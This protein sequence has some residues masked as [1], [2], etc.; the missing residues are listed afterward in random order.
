MGRIPDG[1]GNLV[2]LEVLFA[3][4]NQLSGPIPFDIGRLQKLNKFF[5]DINFLSGTIP[6]SFG[7]LS[8]L[9][10]VGLDFNNLQGNIP[11]SIG[12]CQSLL[13]LSVT[14]NNL[15]GP[16]PPQLL[17]VSSMS[18]I[19][20]LSSNYLTGELPVAVENLKNLGQLRVSQNRLSGLL[21]KTLGSCV[22]LEKLYLDGNLFEGPIPSSLSSLRG[23]EALDLSNNNLSGEIPEFLVRFGALRYLN[24][25]FNNFEGVIPSGG[26]FKNASATFVE[27][28]SKLCGGIPELHMLRCNLK[29][30]SSNSLRLEVAIIVGSLGAT[31]AF[32]CLL[33]LWIGKKKEKQATTTSVE[34][35]VLQ[36]SYQ[37]IVRATDGF[38]T[39]NLVGSGSFGS[40]YKGVLQASG[41]VI[42]VKVLNLLNR[43]ASRSFLAECEALKNIRHRNLVKVL[44]AISGE[45]Y[46][47]NDFKALVYEFME[48]GSLED[49]LHPLIGMNEPETVRNLNFFQRVSVA[50]DVA[51]ALEYL[52]HHCEEP[53]IHC[54]LKPSN[55]LLD[56][57]MV[58]HISDFG[59]AKILS[60]DR[61]NYSAN[62]SGSLGLRGTIGY[63]PPE[64]GMGSGLSTKGD[65]Y[66]YGILLLEMFTGKRPTDERFR[67]GLS[68]R[69]FVKAAL[70]ERIVEVTDPIL[71]E[72][73]VA[74][75]TPG[76]KNSRNDR[77]LRCLNSLF[78]I[79]LTCSAESPN[80]RIDMSD[81]VIKLCSIR[82][83]F[84]PTRLRHEVPT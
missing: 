2:N 12:K 37:S 26:I 58:G 75:G 15:S 72:E 60:T 9:T 63:A 74:R 39:Q 19:L 76:V 8:A 82:D 81:V 51:H 44:T 52:H 22:S 7:N 36:L 57:E 30:S 68:L 49:W 23:L 4:Q 25:S 78:E 41:A 40:V 1:I 69:N 13:G 5:A 65:V 38:S 29:T 24:L 35:S 70:P 53:I 66:S 56:E 33:I 32:T 77:H 48:N 28:N 17:G 73:R 55:I 43:G 46:Q 45:D 71:V 10:M 16:I 47:G 80:E 18:I 50:M 6:H 54:D 20:D 79:G 61:L 67:E 83:K 84:H 21:P 59:L 64:Y 42:A 3:S 27:G 62:K 31:L 34:N 14:Y 11:P